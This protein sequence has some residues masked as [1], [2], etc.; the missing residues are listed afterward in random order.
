MPGAAERS[1][2]R[3][4]PPRMQKAMLLRPPA[5]SLQN[6]IIL[7]R[8][9]G[10]YVARSR[11]FRIRGPLH[12]D[13]DIDWDDHVVLLNSWVKIP[14][15][16]L[17]DDFSKDTLVSRPRVYAPSAIPACRNSTF[18]VRTVISRPISQICRSPRQTRFAGKND[19]SE[20][21]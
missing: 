14:N 7:L 12:C 11:S 19:V 3:A 5:L 4:I 10:G 8:R 13:R 6:L 15:D 21:P 16:D 20:T 1:P 9:S 2:D 17:S 18:R